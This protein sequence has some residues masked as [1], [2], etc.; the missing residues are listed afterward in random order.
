MK[1]III[2]SIC[3][4]LF[5]CN[6]KEQTKISRN[7]S[8]MN[9]MEDNN[10][11]KAEGSAEIFENYSI[12]IEEP[13]QE[14]ILEIN[15]E[16]YVSNIDNKYIG[17]YLPK[18]FIE[19]IENTR[20]FGNALMLNSYR[21]NSKHNEF[22]YDILIVKE[23]NIFSDLRFSDGYAICAE[24]I[25]YFEFIDNNQQMVIIDDNGH[26]YIKISNEIGNYYQIVS[27][28]IGKIIFSDLIENGK[29]I[30]S[31]DIITV[32][33]LNL[34]FKMI[35]TWPIDE[36]NLEL[37]NMNHERFALKIENGRY[38]FYNIRYLGGLNWEIIDDIVYEIK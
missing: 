27:N 5:N 25:I 21:H 4:L 8:I 6:N 15:D 36:A 35:L 33:Q 38:I 7:S 10:N 26:Q 31:D 2:I 13:V 9:F 1:Q 17:I 14:N 3:F 29:I 34:N 28:F 23:N 16:Y 30:I 24:K 22:Y 19:S 32:L 20:N 37:D 12:D 11:F 18:Y